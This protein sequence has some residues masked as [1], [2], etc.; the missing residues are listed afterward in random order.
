MIGNLNKNQLK[1]KQNIN[2]TYNQ[3]MEDI[4]VKENIVRVIKAI[5]IIWH[6]HIHIREK[7]E[8]LR[9]MT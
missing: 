3:K 6:E 4:L 8:A 9:R 5:R 7:K 2:N 1:N